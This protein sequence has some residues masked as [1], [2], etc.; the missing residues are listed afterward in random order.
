MLNTNDKKYIKQIFEQAQAPLIQQ[1]EAIS[2]RIFSS[3]Q[4]TASLGRKVASL[5]KT[6]AS[7]GR[8]VASLDK[9]LIGMD[10]KLIGMDKKLIGM[11]KKMIGM[12]KKITSLDK[13]MISLDKKYDRKTNQLDTKIEA[14][15]HDM[16]DQ[17]LINQQDHQTFEE[18]LAEAKNQ[19]YN[20]FDQI[21][22]ELKTMRQNYEICSYR[23]RENGERL[24]LLEPR[25]KII[26]GHL[27]LAD[28]IKD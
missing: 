5:D 13:K 24:D 25:V 16:A 28:V 27:L 7:L 10:K 19:S 3:D 1:L 14:L 18:D 17:F 12:D 22:G 15:R 26:E 11:D 4:T 9:K 6:T 21:V 20:F 8:K 2:Q 23:R